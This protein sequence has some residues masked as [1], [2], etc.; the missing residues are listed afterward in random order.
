LIN[1]KR[2]IIEVEKL[3]HKEKER[4]LY[5]HL[6]MGD[7]P[8]EFRRSLKPHLESIAHNRHFL[9]EIARRLGTCFFTKDL[10]LDAA[11]LNSF[12]ENPA[13]LLGDIIAELDRP[14]YSALALLFMRAGRIEIPVSMLP[15]EEEALRLLGVKL[16]QVRDACHALEG[17]LVTSAIEHGCRYW[18]FRHPSIRDAI[19]ASVAAQ[20]DL[21]DIYLS[22][23]KADDI[24]AEVVCGEVSFQGAK[25]HIPVNRYDRLLEKLQTLDLNNTWLQYG[26]VSFLRTRCPS[27]FVCRWKQRHPEQFEAL[28]CK[29]LGRYEFSSVLAT[30][31]K[32]DMLEENFRIRYVEDAEKSMVE[33]AEGSFLEDDF[34][35]LISPHE[36]DRIISRV[37]S[38]LLPRLTG[39]IIAH[40]DCFD[41]SHDDPED[42]FTDW[43][44]NL[45]AFEDLHDD[46]EIIDA[47][48]EAL[49]L[50]DDAEDRL[51]SKK[52]RHEEKEKAKKEERADLEEFDDYWDSLVDSYGLPKQSQN[53]QV[54]QMHALSIPL[55]PRSIFDDV[56]L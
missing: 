4:I 19:G 22:G 26:F 41:P 38:E 32:A 2:V 34:D 39:E 15:D 25:V 7:Q 49:A 31:K 11:S 23:A 53:A 12:V 44:N 40:E 48:R 51:S 18:K 8:P 42:H 13:K 20:P 9:P 5:N 21:I 55:P 29:A 46:E 36:V 6:R 27:S 14:S 3:S 28:F 54:A 37:K 17:T 1:E 35:V 50:I 30:L 10:R 43:R 45:Q 56:D 52:E 16:S 33:S 24:V 47:F